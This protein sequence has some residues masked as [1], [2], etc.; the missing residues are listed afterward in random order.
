MKHLIF[1]LD[2]TII[3]SREEIK[4]N[5]SIVFDKI[6]PQTQIDL[7]LLNYSIN[8]TDLLTSVYGDNSEI[9]QAAKR[10]FS[11]H[12]D[13]SSFNETSLY[14]G[15][16]ETLDFL[17]RQG[18]QLY[19]ATN[20]RLIPTK[21]ILKIKNINHYFCD[22]MANEMIAGV[23]MTKRAML[24]ELKKKHFIASGYMIGDSV[25]DIKAGM[26]ENLKTIAVSY[27]YEQVSLLRAQKPDFFIDRFSK[28][29]YLCDL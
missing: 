26:E 29:V 15:V 24:S 6:Q 11:E 5:Y 28:L 10:I 4:K 22:V 3:D 23:N 25:Q 18:H 16:D 2:G 27:G 14:D 20:K 21:R 1:D 13:N 17:K 9:I 8:I 12:Y 19:I 7:D